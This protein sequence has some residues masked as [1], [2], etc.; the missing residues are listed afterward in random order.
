MSKWLLVTCYCLTAL[1]VG[2]ACRIE[3]LNLKSEHF[4]PQPLPGI[5]NWIIPELDVVLERSD[6][7]IYERRQN[8]AAAIAAETGDQ[9]AEVNF[10][11]PYSADEQRRLDNM[12]VLHASHT[13][14]RWWV[15]SFGFA[16]YF[17]APVAFIAAVICLVSL[18]SWPAK[19]SAALCACLNGICILLMLTR[20]YWFV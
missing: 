16:Q 19:S 3:Y 18:S 12:K 11:A 5:E 9:Q 13:N 15:T 8:L 4:L 20:N 10:G 2:V 17:I 14:L 7:L 6:D 1:V